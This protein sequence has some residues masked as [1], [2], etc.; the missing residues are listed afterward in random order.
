MLVEW[1]LQILKNEVVFTTFDMAVAN[2]KE[3]E[4]TPTLI[5]YIYYTILYII[6]YEESRTIANVVNTTEMCPVQIC[7]QHFISLLVKDKHK[8]CIVL[9]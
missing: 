5:L 9:L 1:R 4:F 3:I 7:L 8:M 2:T 6:I